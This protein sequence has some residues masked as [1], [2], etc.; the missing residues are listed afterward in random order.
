MIDD[1]DLDDVVEV[2]NKVRELSADTLVTLG[3]GSISDG[4][5]NVKLGHGNNVKTKED[6]LKI[7]AKIDYASG[8]L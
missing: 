8:T 3:A 4:C 6:L 7:R 1:R 5:K 2:I